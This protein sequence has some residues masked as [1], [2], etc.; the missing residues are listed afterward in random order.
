MAT[1]NWKFAGTI[2]PE[3]VT[4][5]DLNKMK[6]AD[7]ILPFARLYMTPR[8]IPTFW[9]LQILDFPVPIFQQGLQF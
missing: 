5:D 1:T 6:T 7:D 3:N 8:M 2:V 9:I 4:V